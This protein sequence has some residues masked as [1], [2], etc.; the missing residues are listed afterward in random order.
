MIATSR[1]AT[2]TAG[3]HVL[4]RGTFGNTEQSATKA[5]TK[6]EGFGKEFLK[7]GARQ[8]QCPFVLLQRNPRLP[9]QL[10]PTL[11]TLRVAM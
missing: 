7:I 9:P 10:L 4:A 2:S 11:I 1:C 3:M 5:Q 8:T 6:V